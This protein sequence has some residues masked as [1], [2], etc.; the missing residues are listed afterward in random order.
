MTNNNNLNL[1]KILYKKTSKMTK[2][3]SKSKNMKT[4]KGSETKR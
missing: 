1:A 4:N 3:K 2:F